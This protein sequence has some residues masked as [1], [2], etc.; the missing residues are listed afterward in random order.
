MM[1]PVR[2]L[3]SPLALLY[4]GIIGIR[5]L[6]YRMRI[7]TRTQFD[8]PIICVGNIAVGG[9][10][11][12]P[13]I[14]WLIRA[15]G[16]E[17]E[18]G[19]LSR[20]YKRKTTGYLKASVLSTAAE[21]GDEPAQLV[22]KFPGIQLAVS[23]S[24]VLGVP[25]LLGD[26]PSLQAILM[27]DG[28]QH[29]PIKP[30]LSIILTDYHNLFTS[31]WIMPAGTLR[32]FRSAYKRADIIIITKCPDQLSQNEADR[33]TRTI[34]PLPHQSVYFTCIRY[35]SLVPVFQNG[36]QPP[37]TIQSVLGFSGLA[38]NSYF[39]AHLQQQYPNAHTLSHADHKEY[40]TLLLSDIAE[41]FRNLQ[42]DIVITTEKDAV[43]L[44]TEAG[45]N[46]LGNLP[47]FA[48]PIEVGFPLGNEE[49]LLEHVRKYI[50][51]ATPIDESLTS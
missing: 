13:H 10:G 50:H 5:N 26:A 35:G 3:L 44:Q 19:V 18:L 20:G 21:I 9:T 49:M 47:V 30:G 4:A 42:A 32:E 48:L 6:L 12:T 46:I 8:F 39:A 25:H 43:K 31:D 36:I 22:R 37:A 51:Q 14:E 28:F 15:L 27:D 33:I 24:R 7:L 38:N 1:F 16:S 2:L 11:K 45:K 41:R 23:E 17:F 29:L 34:K 40:S